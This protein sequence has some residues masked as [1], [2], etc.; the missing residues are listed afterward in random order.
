[1]QNKKTHIT[2]PNSTPSEELYRF[3]A[4]GNLRLCISTHR[5]PPQPNDFC[6]KIGGAEGRTVKE[7]PVAVSIARRAKNTQTTKKHG[8]FDSEAEN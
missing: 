2:L 6:E 8:C 5:L 4:D 1:M 3:G 7:P